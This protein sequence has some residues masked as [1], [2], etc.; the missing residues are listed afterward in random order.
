MGQWLEFRETSFN[1]KPILIHLRTGYERA[2]I[3]PEK[4]VQSDQQ[5]P[6]PGTEIV[7]EGNIVAFYP[8]ET[9]KRRSVYFVGLD[10]DTVYELQ[11]GSSTEGIRQPLKINR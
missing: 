8:T 2:I 7:V 4:V 6:L 11:V 5:I 10:T 1:N 3:M 9:F